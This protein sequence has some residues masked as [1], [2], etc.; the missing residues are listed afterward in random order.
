MVWLLRVARTC[1][2][3]TAHMWC[4][5]CST[6]VV[7]YFQYMRWIKQ[8]RMHRRPD[9]LPQTVVDVSAV[10]HLPCCERVCPSLDH[11]CVI[12]SLASTEREFRQR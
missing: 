11:S 10:K 6:A 4:G 1:A 8:Q 2:S 7:P 12:R 9:T 5:H 3:A